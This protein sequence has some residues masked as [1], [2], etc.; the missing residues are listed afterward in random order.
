MKFPESE[1]EENSEVFTICSV[2]GTE[3]DFDNG[4]IAGYWGIMPVAFCEW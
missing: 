3:T 1:K 2:C 4:G